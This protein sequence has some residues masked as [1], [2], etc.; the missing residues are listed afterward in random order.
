MFFDVVTR[1]V[2]VP[3]IFVGVLRDVTVL[4]AVQPSLGYEPVARALS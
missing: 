3:R 2:R 1:C 4:A